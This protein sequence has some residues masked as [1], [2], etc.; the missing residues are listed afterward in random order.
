VVETI[1]GAKLHFKSISVKDKLFLTQK[2]GIPYV[3]STLLYNRQPNLD[4]IDH[5]L[6]P[7]LK[8]LIPDP[9]LLLGMQKAINRIIDAIKL[10]EKI[11]IYGDY[12]V[13]GAT[14][15]ALF[16]KYFKAL[17][18]NVKIYI[19]DR[20]SE[21]YG[22][23][24]SAFLKLKELGYNLCIT[25]DCGIMAHDEIKFAKENKLDV[26]VVDHHMSI[27]TLPDAEAVVNPNRID[28][29]NV[30]YTE[31]LAA[32]GVSFLVLIAVNTTLRSI[33]FFQQN[34][35]EEPNLIDYL[36]IVALG[37]VCDIVKLTGINR[38]LVKQGLKVIQ[39][40]KNLGLRT[41]I[42]VLGIYDEIT[43]YHL[44]YI[45]GPH[46]NAGGRLSDSSLG[47]ELLSTD[48]PQRAK[49]IAVTL[50][51]LNLKRREIEK[52]AFDE[53]LLKVE[54]TNDKFVM[55]DSENWHQGIIG[56]VASR[57]K[58]HFHLPTI[59]ISKDTEIGKAS[60]RSIKG[61]N[62]GAA[63]ISA[64]TENLIIEGGGHEMA[65]GFSVENKKILDLKNFFKKQFHDINTEK[66][67]IIDE[68]IQ[69]NA[70]TVD[71]CQQ[72]NLLAPYGVGNPE[73]KFIISNI[74]IINARIINNQHI[75][76]IISDLFT[77]KSIRAIAFQIIN[78]KLGNSILCSNVTKLLVKIKLEYWQGRLNPQLIIEDGVI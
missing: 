30:P 12:D 15:S 71:F 11:V 52:S 8:N 57:L 4:E 43:T 24:K 62:L 74:R 35:I 20:I 68:E 38:A 18:L 21:G 76:C 7:K 33:N 70:I 78:S 3:I 34:N 31:N 17:G 60:A 39:K 45:I 9:F 75:S 65:A 46:I 48:D 19:P 36:D 77:G 14:S 49:D 59:V 47:S 61:T 27:D 50:Q 58:D 63:V 42:D 55:V 2:Y 29:P 37:T 22:P 67:I 66:I 40:R 5:F 41:L 69:L 73:P 44:G 23:N 13:D 53:A 51:S 54:Y 26:I 28:Q 64:K 32:V 72:L 10:D 25:V 56:I 16:K 1:N 6:S